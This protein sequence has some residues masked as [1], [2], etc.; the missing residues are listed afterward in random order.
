MIKWWW[1][2]E[3]V[4]T[5]KGDDS[6]SP[7]GASKA[8]TAVIGKMSDL[9]KPGAISSGEFRVADLLPDLGSPKANWKQNSGV[10]REIIKRGN[11]I[12]DVSPY[13]MDN[14]GFLGA[15]RNLLKNHGW[16]YSDGYW[17]PPGR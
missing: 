15:E 5:P 1:Q 2:L 10:L 9:N 13:P 4:A 12:K 6:F 17:Y 7:K 8:E 3:T 11:P 14:V 16:K